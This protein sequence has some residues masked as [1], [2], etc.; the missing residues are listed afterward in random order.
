MLSQ[1][2]ELRNKMRRSGDIKEVRRLGAV[3]A[4]DEITVSAPNHRVD[5]EALKRPKLGGKEPSDDDY[6]LRFAHALPA[7]S[8]G[9]YGD[10]RVGAA[11]FGT[12][13]RRGARVLRRPE[14]CG[15]SRN[16]GH[17]THALVRSHA[18]GVGPGTVDGRCGEDS[19][20]SGAQAK[21]GWT[22]CRASVG[23]VVHRTLSKDLASGAGGAGST[24]TV[25]AP[26]EVGVDAGR[27]EKPDA[28]AGHGR[29]RLS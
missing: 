14:G 15:S 11:P 1:R 9:R 10:G 25:V 24:A 7:D 2:Q 17:R 5:L 13:K 29:G 12:R 16:R 23:H 27:S 22:G 6:R 4:A 3:I 21:D 20:G 18:V 8:D 19:G 28:C 26:A